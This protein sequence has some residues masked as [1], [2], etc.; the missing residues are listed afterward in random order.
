MLKNILKLEGAQEIAKNEQKTIHGGLFPS[1]YN[2]T[3][4]ANSGGEWVCGGPTIGCGC[5]FGP[6][7]TDK[8]K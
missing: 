3:W 5:V 7:P 2:S 1:T 8:D 6:K 4:C